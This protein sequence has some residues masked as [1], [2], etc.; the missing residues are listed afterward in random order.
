MQLIMAARFQPEVCSYGNIFE[1][2]EELL[3]PSLGLFR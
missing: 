2:Q 3:S 1:S